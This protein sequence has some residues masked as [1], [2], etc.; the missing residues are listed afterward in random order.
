MPDPAYA[1]P[2]PSELSR[3]G[4]DYR[5]LSF[6]CQLLHSSEGLHCTGRLT[7]YYQSRCKGVAFMPSDLASQPPCCNGFFDIPPSYGRVRVVE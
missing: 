2:G 4:L 1:L 5:T 7:M 3:G 6:I